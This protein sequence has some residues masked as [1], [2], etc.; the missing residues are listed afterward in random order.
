MILWIIFSLLLVGSG[1]LF[2]QFA[3]EIEKQRINA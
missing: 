1:V 3:K 2:L